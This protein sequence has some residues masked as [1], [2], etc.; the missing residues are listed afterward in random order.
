MSYSDWLKT[1]LHIHSIISNQTK[2]NDYDGTEYTADELIKT[3][4]NNN[5][6]L[7]S[8]TDHNILNVD[9]YKD[10]ERTIPKYEGQI[11]YLIGAE[12][13]VYDTAVHKDVFHLLIYFDTQNIDIV[14]KLICDLYGK[15]SVSELGGNNKTLEL[16]EIFR[17]CFNC[18]IE[19]II[20]IPHFNNKHKGLPT[21]D[22]IDSF[23]YTVFNALE[24]SNNRNN[25]IDSIKAFERNEYSD[26]PLVVFS[27]NHNLKIYPNGKNKDSQIIQ[28][29]MFI[30]GNINHPF[31]SVKTAFQDVQTRVYIKDVTCRKLS[32]ASEYIQEL[33]IDGKAI[34]LSPYQNTI[35][36]G[37]GTG[38]S[39]LLNLIQN[40]IDGVDI[41]KYNTLKQHYI[42]FSLKLSDGTPRKSIEETIEKI[43]IIRFDQEKEIYFSASI[44]EK[45]KNDLERKLGITF[46]KLDI[47]SPKD[48]KSLIDSFNEYSLLFHKSITDE[49][50]YEE[51][52]KK[53]TKDYTIENETLS[54]IY[55][56]KDYLITL[57]S[58][59]SLEQKSLFFGNPLY[60]DQ[61]REN[62]TLTSE[63]IKSKNNNASEITT[64]VNH[65]L[66]KIENKIKEI[67]RD[68][69]KRNLSLS[70]NTDILKNIREYLYEYAVSLKKLKTLCAK[71][72][73]TYSEEN[74]NQ[75][76][77]QKK[78]NNIGDTS[79]KMRCMYNQKIEY[80]SYKKKILKNDYR[81]KPF[82]IGIIQSINSESPFSGNK[83]FVENLENFLNTYYAN[84]T[85]FEYDL[86]EG[87]DSLKHKSAGERANLIMR[88]I[89]NQV[90]SDV[91]N[92]TPVIVIID[93]PED[94]LDNKGITKEVVNKIRCMKINNTLPQIICVTH[95]ANISIM[96]DS[97][98]IIVAK[99]ED[100][101]CIY[102]NSGI[103]DVK[104]IEN[105]CNIVEGGTVA[106]KK[107]GEKFNIPFIKTINE[108]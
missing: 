37:F 82:F 60:S 19:N 73:I 43:K 92:D 42:S 105:V 46:P 32:H 49:F 55:K 22:S 29:Q 23:V 25:L 94:S 30:L 14:E 27:D 33:S 95:N 12:I 5:V 13:D 45:C 93:Q 3:L 102:N 6:N 64:K 80:Q 59:L 28:T 103:E 44:D 85:K 90:E 98:N 36:G 81:N 54:D 26:V 35:I 76:S 21:S 38:K 40:G 7:F 39:F 104:F 87:N 18:E 69:E 101:K 68:I 75:I 50:N 96:A 66:N 4:I 91:K 97:E 86:L 100:G 89:F 9:L 48:E 99:K 53:D 107:R 56:S 41:E 24:D 31:S 67:S 74:F 71:F 47:I 8:I 65:Y 1:D 62:I 63:L 78:E 20:T 15:K 16:S 11:N 34:K 84:F 77:E 61:E 79:F 57:Y 2:K 72:E 10:I 52:S 83:S 108:V 70:S 58:N 106:L 51:L 17:T 88:V